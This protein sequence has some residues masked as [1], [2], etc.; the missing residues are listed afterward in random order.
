VDPRKIH[1]LY[2]SDAQG[3]LDRDL[4]DDVGYGI[5]SR[6]RD[7]LEVAEAWRGRV[8]CWG[9]DTVI[10]RRQGKVVAYT[11]HGP[12]RIGGDEERLACEGCGW[13]I[14]WGDYRKS[15]SGQYLDATGLEDMF[16]AFTERWPSTLSPQAR[17]LLID[18]LIH[19]FHC[20]DGTTV[21]SPVGATVI[22]ASAEEVL[23]LLDELAY[24]PQSSDGL[25]ETRQRWAARLE[26]KVRQRPMSELRAIARELGIRGRSRMRRAELQAAIEQI[27]PDRLK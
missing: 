10:Q 2:E 18:R 21:G 24:G 19:E 22:R 27:A 16:A 25:P 17:L 1:R 23:A 4:L 11:G 5:Y 9:C 20:W 15:L 6:C 26:A 14:A 12:T 13:Q 7:L 3:M 8:K